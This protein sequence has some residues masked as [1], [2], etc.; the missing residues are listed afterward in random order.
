MDPP[1]VVE[2]DF[3]PDSVEEVNIFGWGISRALGTGGQYD[4]RT[5]MTMSVASIAHTP[6][7]ATVVMAKES[8]SLEDFR[9]AL[10]A[11]KVRLR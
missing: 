2:V 10:L 9:A 6:P 5:H 8:L 1:H 3:L 7:A 11:G 4:S